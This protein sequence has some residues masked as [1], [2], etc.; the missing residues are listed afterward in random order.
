V[1]ERQSIKCVVWDLD[2]TIWDGVLLENGG[3]RLTDGV[4]DVI[5]ALDRRGILH[6]IA[7]RNAREPALERLERFGLAEYFL[8]PQIHWGSKA[9]S[10]REISR[11]LNIGVA[12]I[13]FVDDQDFELDAV[14]FAIPEVL[15]VDAGR[16]E[17][18]TSM[19]EMTPR[20]ATEDSRL[21]RHMY[22]ADIERNEAEAGFA[23]ESEAFLASLNMVMTVTPA[24][25]DD[26]KR[27][28]ELTERTHQF[29]TSGH[30]YSYEE[31]EA[32]RRSSDHRLL[33]ARLD[34]RYG[35]YGTVGLALV[36]C[37][38]DAW[39]LKSFFMS[40]RVL[41]R[42]VASVLLCHLRG[43]ASRRR[44]R[45]LAEVKPNEE[46]LLT[47]VVYKLA[48]FREIARQNGRVLY[49]DSSPGV[50]PFPRYLRVITKDRASD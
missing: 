42:G 36:E 15:C 1:S 41:S 24:S 33:L 7:S 25:A 30:A 40:C 48:G 5:R 9:A 14:R 47:S 50:A 39:T 17:S 20:F 27:A 3:A 31:L 23:E 18:L 46:N 32:F 6:S 22:L 12:G 2:G 49:E 35:T 13:A 44:V 43:E 19:P 38:Q 28:E 10:I 16:I 45:L 4:A 29:N 37:G 21:R 26:L 34:D 8:H 11:R